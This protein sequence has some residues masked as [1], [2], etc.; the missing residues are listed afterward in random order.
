[1]VSSKTA[2]C[3]TLPLLS[4]HS[5]HPVS[6]LPYHVVRALYTEQYK[7]EKMQKVDHPG[8]ILI[9]LHIVSEIQDCSLIVFLSLWNRFSSNL[10]SFYRIQRLK[11][12][13]A[14]G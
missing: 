8:E 14:L 3:S 9:A 10:P 2:H 4:C 13:I 5:P 1:M 7:E 11:F 6:A 12:P